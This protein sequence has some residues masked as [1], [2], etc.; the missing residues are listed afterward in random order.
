MLRLGFMLA[1][2]VGAFHVSPLLPRG[3]W[4][5]A[6]ALAVVP[7]T[8]SPLEVRAPHIPLEPIRERGA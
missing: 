7:F 3:A 8:P 5:A 2:P 1:A 4:A 6:D